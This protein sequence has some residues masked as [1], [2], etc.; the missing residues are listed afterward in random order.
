MTINLDTEVVS[1]SYDVTAHMNTYTIKR[2]GRRWTV[3]IPD[4]ALA[5]HGANHA[6]RRTHL[7]N[8]LTDAMRGKADGET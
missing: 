3:N 8:L 1:S 6:A 2:D 5:I 7:G 4:T